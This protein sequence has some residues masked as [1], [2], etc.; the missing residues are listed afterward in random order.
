MCFYSEVNSRF[1]CGINSD[2]FVW[3]ILGTS[4]RASAG[5]N[6][7]LMWSHMWKESCS[8]DVGSQQSIRLMLGSHI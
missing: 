5:W 2:N 6:Q 4:D 7:L 8:G 3:T 1:V